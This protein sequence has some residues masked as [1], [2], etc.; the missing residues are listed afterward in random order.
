MQ[1]TVVSFVNM[2]FLHTSY[3][4]SWSTRLSYTTQLMTHRLIRVW[5]IANG[6]SAKPAILD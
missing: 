2:G 1:K 4:F 3:S 5:F 6:L